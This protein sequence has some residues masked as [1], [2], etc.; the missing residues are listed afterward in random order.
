MAATEAREASENDD[1]LR[2]TDA[3][4]LADLRRHADD[5]GR[6][7]TSK[8]YTEMSDYSVS[9]QQGRFGSWNAALDEAGLDRNAHHGIPD[10]VLLEDLRRV[11]EELG[12][13]PSMSEYDREGRF[14]SSNV[15]ARF[16]RW[17]AAKERAG[18]PATPPGPTL[19]PLGR[20]LERMDP[21][22]LGSSAEV[23][24]GP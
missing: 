5:L 19:G 16:G 20:A 23:Y 11:A 9:V 4:L 3:E 17:N 2:P 15:Q 22:E 14:S 24:N 13:S 7:P 12:H 1:D 21:D 6:T 10:E 18:L 8:E